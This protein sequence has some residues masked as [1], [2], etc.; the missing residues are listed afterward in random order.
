MTASNPRG[1]NPRLI[2]E[3]VISDQ[4]RHIS[5]GS[6]SVHIAH[7]YPGIGQDEFLA[8][9]K[10]VN[11]LIARADCMIVFAKEDE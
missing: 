9:R 1:L 6:V 8:L 3:Q 10:Q 7:A 4:L 2:A 11:D 5:Q